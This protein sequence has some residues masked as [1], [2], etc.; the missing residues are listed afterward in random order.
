MSC[1]I[2]LI[3]ILTI[4]L[5]W[6][7]HKPDRETIVS[8]LRHENG[9]IVANEHTRQHEFFF[10]Y[11]LMFL[12]FTNLWANSV[13]DKLTI[14]LFFFQENRLWHFMQIVSSI[15]TKFQSLFS[16]KIR[17]IS[18]CR[19]LKSLYSIQSIKINVLQLCNIFKH[20]FSYR[21]LPELWIYISHISKHAHLSSRC[22]LD[23]TGPKRP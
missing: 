4:I 3:F 6:N 10:L 17:N 1:F 23:N 14:F 22:G 2:G 18:K 11:W 15:R 9:D 12:S 19:L 13:D 20:T 5:P 8:I 7:R 21:E 16:G